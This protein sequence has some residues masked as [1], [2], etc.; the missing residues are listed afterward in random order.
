[1]SDFKFDVK[2][3][4]SLFSLDIPKGYTDSVSAVGKEAAASEKEYADVFKEASAEDMVEMFRVWVKAKGGTFPDALTPENFMMDIEPGKLGD[5]TDAIALLSH[6]KLN[7][8]S[9]L[10]F[11]LFCTL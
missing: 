10:S 11:W 8:D 5:H 6:H 2:L 7:S 3:D 4:K 9:W 1:M